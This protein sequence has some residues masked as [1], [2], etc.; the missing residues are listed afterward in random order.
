[1]DAV[2]DGV[3]GGLKVVVMA[4]LAFYPDIRIEPA[5]TAERKAAK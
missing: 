4:S 2:T 5:P 3:R 1:M